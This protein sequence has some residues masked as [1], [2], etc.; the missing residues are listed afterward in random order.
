[1]FKYALVLLMFI[2]TCS[3]SFAKSEVKQLIAF[4]SERRLELIGSNNKVLKSYKIMLG[5]NPVGHK[6]Q[7]GDNKTPEGTYTLEFKNPKSNFNKAFKIS[8]PNFKDRMKARAL[9]VNPGGDIMLHGFPN[10]FKEM[11]AWLETVGLAELGD[12]LIRAALPHLDWTNGCIAVTDEE[13]NEIYELV[14]VPTKI[15]IKP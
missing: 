9:G 8:Y 15:I 11:T 13:I 6:V 2:V 5:R 4:K 7:E 1:M 3:D 12:E 14:D 10:N